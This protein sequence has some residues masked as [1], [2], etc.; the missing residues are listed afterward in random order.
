M[1]KLGLRPAI[2]SLGIFV[3]N[4]RYCVFAVWDS[5]TSYWPMLDYLTS[6]WSMLEQYVSCTH[7]MYSK[8]EV[9]GV[10]VQAVRQLAV[11]APL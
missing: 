1:W 2:S 6:Y 10:D 4:F 3:S 9:W 11:G 7:L 5:L 8:A